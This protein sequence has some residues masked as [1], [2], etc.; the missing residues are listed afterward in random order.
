MKTTKSIFA[1]GAL[2]AGLSACDGQATPD[3]RG[4]PLAQLNGTISTATTTVAP[5]DLTA[6]LSWE[7][8]IKSPGSATTNECGGKPIV[9]IPG[10]DPV[11]VPV[12]GAFPARFS[13]QVFNP[14][15]TDMIDQ[16]GI[17]RAKVVVFQKS[18][19]QVWGAATPDTQLVYVAPEFKQGTVP[20]IPCSDWQA[21]DYWENNA[22]APG[23][24]LLQATKDCQLATM[25][26][27]PAV[28]SK[29]LAEATQGLATALTIEIDGPPAPAVTGPCPT[30]MPGGGSATATTGMGP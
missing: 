21:S 27:G 20:T 3:Y 19:A 5:A 16:N 6:G 29:R 10:P 9:T 7:A 15:S 23:Y 28:S 22:H 13:L 2:I 26:A 4:V 11:E 14:P 17:A 18:T 30:A 24:Y 12:T 1:V 25:A 8:P